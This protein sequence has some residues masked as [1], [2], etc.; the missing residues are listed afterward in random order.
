M[1]GALYGLALAVAYLVALAASVRVLV[2][3]VRDGRERLRKRR[4]GE[5]DRYTEDEEYGP[6]PPEDDDADSQGLQRV[7]CRSCGA[8]NG[9]EF[10]FC[11]R[12]AEQL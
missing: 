12:C 11:R 7:F 2:G 5:L 9:A 3:I 8:E 6:A 1:L 10:A 4:A